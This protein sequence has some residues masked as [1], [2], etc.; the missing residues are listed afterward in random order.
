[1]RRICTLAVLFGWASSTPAADPPA[2]VVLVIH[3]GAGVA[4]RARFTAEAEK[5]CR[6]DLEQALKAGHAALKSGSSLDAVEAAIKFM[7]D[8]PRFN[9][10][11]GAVFTRDGTNEMDATIMEGG[12]LKAGAVGGVSRIKNPITAAR[13]VMEKSEHVLLI[14]AGAERFVFQ[15]GVTEVSP[16]YFWTSERFN[17]MLRHA[18]RVEKKQAASIDSDGHFG[19]VGAVALDA[20]GH[21]A[22]GTSTGGMTY[23][24]SGRLGDS[25]IIGAGTYADDRAC[26]VSCTGHGEE[27]IR[28]AVAF[29]IASRMRHLKLGV[30][31]SADAVFAELPKE[32][33]GV[34][35]LIALD[36]EGRV[37]MPFNT[38]GM[39]RGTITADGVVS[40]MVFEK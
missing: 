15:H 6:A 33:K 2:K 17:E 32:E 37:A 30:K 11:R 29:D 1:M 27:F 35:G 8:S 14:G 39:F 36:R 26:G 24:M 19:T 5:A 10:G 20:K 31:E 28:H 34:G 25:P 7:E 3:G 38:N 22:A 23:K 9:A 4:N 12:T 13:T 40:V 16:R 21:L 18:E